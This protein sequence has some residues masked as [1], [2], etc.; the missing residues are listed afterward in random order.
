[1]LQTESSAVAPREIP[2][3][4]YTALVETESYVR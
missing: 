2:W 4:L 1:M 3:R